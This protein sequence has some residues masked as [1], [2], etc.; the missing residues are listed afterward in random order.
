MVVFTLQVE[1]SM[2]IRAV[3]Y[4]EDDSIDRYCDGDWY[5]S[6]LVRSF[7]YHVLAIYL[8]LS[9]NY[10][11]IS[12]CCDPSDAVEFT[13]VIQ[14]QL[15]KPSLVYTTEMRDYALSGEVVVFLTVH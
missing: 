11:L 15:N 9:A 14:P 10:L 4:R 6:G 12:Q 2:T 1:S 8:S 13:Y 5:K 7:N 3:A